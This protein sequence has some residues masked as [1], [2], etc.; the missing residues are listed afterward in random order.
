MKK[1]TF[2]DTEFM[3]AVEKQKVLK[4]WIL[5]FKSK[6]DI[7]KFS[8]SL[9]NHLIMHCSFIA[10]YNRGGFYDVYFVNPS[11]TQHFLNQFD[12]KKDC[13]SVECGYDVWI[14]GDYSDLNNAMIDEI[15]PYLND[16]RNDLREKE[17]GNALENL[18][19]A[20]E[21]VNSFA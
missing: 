1:Y 10:H 19:I 2:S 4:A 20:Q 3:S 16:I 9:Y 8:K 13:M 14:H 11:D 6:F 7:E 15:Q 12:K 21:R 18:R 17:K 5:F